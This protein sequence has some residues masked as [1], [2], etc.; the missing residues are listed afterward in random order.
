MGGPQVGRSCNGGKET[1]YP[2][3]LIVLGMNTCRPARSQ[4]QYWLTYEGSIS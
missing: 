1:L 4:Q 3:P 2:L